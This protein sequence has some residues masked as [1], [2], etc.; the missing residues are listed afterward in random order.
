[1]KTANHTVTGMIKASQDVGT[2]SHEMSLLAD[3]LSSCVT[4]R[5]A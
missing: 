2:E 5:V 3:V 1:M 4:V